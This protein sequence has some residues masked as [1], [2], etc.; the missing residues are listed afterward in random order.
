MLP[1]DPTPWLMTQQGPAAVRARCIL[2]LNHPDDPSAVD[3][4]IASLA[5]RQDSAGSISGSPLH[6]AGALILLADL[7][8]E[9]SSEI[10]CAASEYLL[11]VLAAQRGHAKASEITPGSL[12]TPCDLGGFFGPYDRRDEPEVLAGGAREMN[13]LREFAPL[14]GP[15][16]PVRAVRRSRL[17]RAGPPS[18]YS[19]GLVPLTFIIEA[20]CRSGFAGDER[21]APALAALLGAQRTTGGWC[22]NLYGHPDCS[23][24]ALRALAAHPDLR[25]GEAADRLLTF[26]RWTQTPEGGPLVRWWRGNKL[27]AALQA[28]AAFDHPAARECIRFGLES[29]APRQQRNGTFG[30]PHRVERVA[31]VLVAQRAVN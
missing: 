12:T 27:Y 10:I 26:Y 20:L 29:I 3:E 15:Q 11:A 13:A 17:D 31:S 18:C 16:S 4:T 14:L 9:H 6:T 21:L 24:H 19:W 22:R 25:D 30:T 28:L 1:Y 8:S 7:N 5:A 23:L 2:G